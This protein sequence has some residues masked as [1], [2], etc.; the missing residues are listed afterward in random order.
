MKRRIFIPISI[1]F[2]IFNVFF[3]SFA[4]LG[5]FAITYSIKVNHGVR[6][7]CIIAGFAVIF[8]LFSSINFTLKGKIHLREKDIKVHNEFLPKSMRTQFKTSIE[9]AQI[10]SI[11][12]IDSTRNSKNQYIKFYNIKANPISKYLEFTLV[13]NREKRILINFYRK[14]QIIKIL[15]YI[16]INMQYYGNEN[17]LVID[18]IMKDWYVY[19]PNK[20]K[21]KNYKDAENIVE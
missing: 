7:D 4:A 13:N 16:S 19:L 11:K 18:D 3:F 20:K 21:N 10:K 12:I 6:M 2:A 9:Y 14:K 5:I 15:T 8:F 17:I 1:S